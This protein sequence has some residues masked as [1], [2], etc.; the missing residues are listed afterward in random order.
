MRDNYEVLYTRFFEKYEENQKDKLFFKEEINS[1][2]DYIYNEIEYSKKHIRF[3]N[4]I[5]TDF[6]YDLKA[7]EH[8]INIFKDSF[9]G[10][11]I[12]IKYPQRLSYIFAI[13]YNYFKSMFN[14]KDIDINEAYELIRED[15]FNLET[16][17]SLKRAQNDLLENTVKSYIKLNNMGKLYDKLRKENPTFTHQETL[18]KLSSSKK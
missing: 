4:G 12:E 6:P 16:A 2:L 18:N 9:I 17:P 3:K 14:I 1:I 10:D 15:A 5:E 7:F 11:N 13:N 8:N